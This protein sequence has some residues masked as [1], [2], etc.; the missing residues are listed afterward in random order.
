MPIPKIT[1]I[2]Y[3]RVLYVRN[4]CNRIY[5]IACMHYDTRH[6]DCLLITLCAY[7]QQG[8]AF[9]RVRL[10]IENLLLNVICCL[11]FKFK[12]TQ[13]G[14]VTQILVRLP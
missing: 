4:L 9:G 1:V 7:A 6:F 5:A 11:L 8:Y 10:Y 3:L 14:F 12:R 2:I 13:C